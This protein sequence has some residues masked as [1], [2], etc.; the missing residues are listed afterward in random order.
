[1]GD[2]FFESEIQKFSKLLDHNENYWFIIY[3]FIYYLK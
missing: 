2:A 3:L 1:M